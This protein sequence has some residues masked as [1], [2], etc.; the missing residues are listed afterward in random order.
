MS[1]PPTTLTAITSANG[2]SNTFL[3]VEAGDPVPWSKPDKL[4]YD[5]KKPLPPLG[6]PKPGP[7]F[8]AAFC[9]GHV[10]RIPATTD[11]KTLRC[12]INWTNSTPFKLP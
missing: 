8:F 6:G 1:G 7:Y 11:E 2:T 10:Q 4:V 9:D 5:P 12:M 3:V